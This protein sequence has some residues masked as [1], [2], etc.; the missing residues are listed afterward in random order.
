M[1][2]L[3]LLITMV[4]LIGFLS[5]SL[6]SA[7]TA[8]NT[9]IPIFEGLNGLFK[10]NEVNSPA[11]HI[12]M[13]NIHVYDS[14]I[15]LDIQDAEWSIFSDTNSMDPVLD[16]DSNGIEIKPNSPEDI[17]IGDI[18]SYKSNIIDGII[19][20][21]V[22]GTGGDEQGWFATAKGDNNP[23]KDPEKVRFEQIQGIVVAIIY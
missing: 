18:I 4:F 14:R 8:K 15:L 1:K 17:M 9:A 3:I 13:Q 11:N 21:R 16:K 10:A 19:V 6:F 20:H 22:V 5:N 7:I 23:E 12:L 2:R